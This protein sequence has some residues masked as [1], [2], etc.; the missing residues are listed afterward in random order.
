MR[1]PWHSASGNRS[2]PIH[3]P[4]AG[5]REGSARGRSS[6]SRATSDRCCRGVVRTQ[7]VPTG[8]GHSAG[9][10]S[11]R[12]TL[13]TC[14]SRRSSR[15]P[16]A[17]GNRQP[18]AKSSPLPAMPAKARRPLPR[19]RRSPPH[20]ARARAPRRKRTAP[21]CGRRLRPRPCCTRQCGRPRRSTRRLSPSSTRG[22]GTPN[23]EKTPPAHVI[24]QPPGRTTTS[25]GV[26]VGGSS[27]ASARI[28][29]SVRGV[30]GQPRR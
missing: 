16:I 13:R 14:G 25:R 1:P 3:G 9:S 2:A 8:N 19:R 6:P 28:R 24:S 20:A 5:D 11:L 4:S 15:K 29:V 17:A 23:P 18:T 22:S 27:G 30:A 12:R 7:I 26:A 21:G 10:R